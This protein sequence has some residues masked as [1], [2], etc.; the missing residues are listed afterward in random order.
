MKKNCLNCIY[1]QYESADYLESFEDGYS[2]EGRD[3]NC[4]LSL[5]NKHDRQLQNE[6]YREKSKK[7]CILKGAK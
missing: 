7:C 3:Y 2:C 4:S 1:L 6:K 5:E